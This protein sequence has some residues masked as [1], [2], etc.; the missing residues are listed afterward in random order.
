MLK[1][2]H[3]LRIRVRRMKCWEMWMRRFC[4]LHCHLITQIL[5]WCYRLTQ[6]PQICL[7]SPQKKPF[8]IWVRSLQPGPPRT[9]ASELLLMRCWRSLGDKDIGSQR[10]P[11]TVANTKESGNSWKM[12]WTL[13]LLWYCFWHIKSFVSA[14]RNRWAPTFVL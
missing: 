2:L 7:M 10:I 14:S 9:A 5:M 13:C 1:S 3:W 8:L 11:N 4:H 6:K 12:W